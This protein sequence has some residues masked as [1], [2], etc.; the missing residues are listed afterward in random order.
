MLDK[1]GKYIEPATTNRVHEKLK[2]IVMFRNDAARCPYCLGMLKG[3]NTLTLFQCQCSKEFQIYRPVF[4]E[5]SPEERLAQENPLYMLKI[6]FLINKLVKVYVTINYQDDIS[7]LRFEGKDVPDPIEA[8]HS[9]FPI[10]NEMKFRKKMK[11]YLT[12]S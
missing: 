1:N 8:P 9:N 5:G 4:T 3:T 7:T 2:P 6:K 11:L 12:F 10:D